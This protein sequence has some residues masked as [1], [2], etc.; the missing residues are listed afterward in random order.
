MCNL[1]VVV[2]I[3]LIVDWSML[4]TAAVAPVVVLDLDHLGI[5]QEGQ[6]LGL[7]GLPEQ[8]RVWMQARESRRQ[9]L[10]GLGTWR[11]WGK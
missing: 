4:D 7:L 1:Q 11:T 9:H 8:L 3:D 10:F 5:L 2:L 6:D